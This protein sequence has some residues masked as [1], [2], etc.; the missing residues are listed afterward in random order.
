VVFKQQD[1]QLADTSTRVLPSPLGVENGKNKI[2]I[3]YRSE[4]AKHCL[5]AARLQ[6][7][8]TTVQK[9]TSNV[10]SVSSCRSRVYRA[11]GAPTNGPI[12]TVSVLST[13]H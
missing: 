12:I 13:L 7:T 4:S 2:L 6:Q 1:G 11:S 10:F 3:L 5:H 9:R 8:S